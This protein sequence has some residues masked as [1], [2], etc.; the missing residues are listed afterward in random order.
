MP[1][2][3]HELV[4]GT[5]VTPSAGT[6]RD[7]VE[8]AELTEAVGLDTVTI[9]DHPYNAEYLDTYTLL[10]WIAARTTRLRVSANVTSLPLRPP[11]VLARMAASLDILSGGRFEMGLGAGLP[12]A[13][14]RMTGRQ[15]SAGES[16]DALEEA[17]DILR[18]VWDTGTAGPLRHHGRHYEIPQM[19]RGP[20]PA[21]DITISLG[22]YKPRMLG[23]VGRKAD[24]WLPT[25]DYIKDPDI[26]TSNA[27]ID[28]AATEAG[29][30]PR[31]IR[32]HL[33][34]F[35]IGFTPVGR[36][37]LQGPPEQWV[38]DL[39]SLIVE[40][41]F[42]SFYIGGDDPAMIRTFGEEV[43]PALRAE[44]QEHRRGA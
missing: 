16:V 14:S 19:R 40:H 15:L 24:G 13:A 1:D 27:L 38:D 43:A 41:G 31:D 2:Y 26:A 20:R 4:L 23:L 11:A 37:F 18:G 44:V 5:F 42:S 7:V 39:L 28:A 32:R 36:A 21:H 9:Q 29:R 22:A 12:T 30:D 10:T 34:L 3:G 8:L 33:N 17:I 25:L 35:D 6:A